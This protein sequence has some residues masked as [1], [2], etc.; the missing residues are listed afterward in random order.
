MRQT[1]VGIKCPDDAMLPRSARTGV[2]K[3][4]QIVKTLLAGVV[5]VVV[6]IP[7]AYV[8]LNLAGIL[9]FVLAIA[10]GYGAGT[11]VYRVGGRNG[12]PLAVLVSVIAVLVAFFPF[13]VPSLLVGA[14][15]IGQVLPMIIAVVSAGFAGRGGY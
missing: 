15:S 11:L 13:L 5:V 4:D 9:T 6:G 12:G 14:F 8:L 7:I 3:P 10:A 1:E 2:M